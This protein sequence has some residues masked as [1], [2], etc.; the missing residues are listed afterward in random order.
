MLALL[1]FSE[2]AVFGDGT[3]KAAECSVDC[4][5]F[6]YFRFGHLFSL[7]PQ[8]TTTHGYQ[9]SLYV[10]RKEGVNLGSMLKSGIRR[11]QP[12]QFFPAE[13]VQMDMEY[14]LSRILSDIG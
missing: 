2:N 10:I 7:P 3:L 6:A 12:R 13:D 9:P 11:V 5:V 14:D 8:Q 4:F 1:H